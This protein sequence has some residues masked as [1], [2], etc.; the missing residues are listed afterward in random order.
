VI[1]NADTDHIWSALEWVFGRV[2]IV[3][4]RRD[5]SYILQPPLRPHTAWRPDLIPEGD[6]PVARKPERLTV[7]VF[8]SA[9]NVTLQWSPSSSET[10][11]P[12]EAELSHLLP[13][14]RAESNP[15]T[16]WLVSAS[17]AL[18]AI[19]VFAVVFLLISAVRWRIAIGV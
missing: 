18:F 1:Y 4:Q 8:P 9:C 2:G 19:I 11:G 5:N 6:Q 3:W 16:T 10:R 7:N 12:V 13:N 14:M 17:L 15:A